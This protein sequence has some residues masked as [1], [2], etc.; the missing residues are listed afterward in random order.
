MRTLTTR[1]LLGLALALVTL[2][3]AGLFGTAPAAEGRWVAPG[4]PS[5]ST[6][7]TTAV[8]VSW[9]PV[10]GAPRYRLKYS[11]DASF[12][13]AAFL[14]TTN[15][16][17]ELAG[18]R[19]GTRYFIAAAVAK[20]TGDPL[21]GYG[22]TGSVVTRDATSQ[23]AVLPPSGLQATARDNTSL[24]LAW[25]ARSGAGSYEVRYATKSSMS[26]ARSTS[27]YGTTLRLTGLKKN[28]TY[29]VQVRVKSS[30]GA[31]ISTFGK[32]LKT[33]TTSST[34]VAPLRA[35]T[36]NVLCANCSAK[37]PWSSRRNRLVNAIKAQDLDVLGVQEAS[38]G[39]TT[40]A[41]GKRKAQFD[42][43]L[44]LLG[45]RYAITNSHRYNCQKSTSPNNC[46]V[47]NRGASND[48]RI[49]YNA[50]R[51]V[52]LRTGSV[53]FAAQAAGDTKRFLAW[54]EFR[55][56]STGKRFF[57]INT[58][59]D[60]RDDATGSRLHYNLRV[61]QTRELVATIKK[62]NISRLPVIIL[63]DFKVNKYAEPNNAPYDIIT[64]AS[65]V[66]PLGNTYKSTVP[67]RSA[68][69]E[70]RIGTEYNTK[71]NLESTAPKSAYINGSVIDYVFV[72]RGVRV[73]EWQTVVDVDST[74][75]FVATPPS[76]HNM[77]RI[78]AYL[79]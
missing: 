3:A 13:S 4:A 31:I 20:T 18:L 70:R 1:R 5:A 9:T 64:G 74:G 15:P 66:D 63:G 39:L 7:S 41:D 42:D 47:L 53:Q 29:W 73:S 25:K 46:A 35:A 67:A 52:A 40:G 17:A 60:P 12:S 59:L 27:A 44:Y 32:S 23:Y 61:S 30:K 28:T 34:T 26:Q 72:S 76:D 8:A 75:R 79:P 68:T 22:K 65:Y 14:T 10:W 38:Q 49:I 69:V 55:Q 58:H 57:V 16:E 45:S 19:P 62:Q 77:V 2:T 36:Y 21:S 50:Q 56:R 37:Y 51:V 43:L 48:V 78:T 6:R 11:T 33:R 71:N 54:A 24:T